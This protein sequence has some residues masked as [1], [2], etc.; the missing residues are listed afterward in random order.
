MAT[1]EKAM[2]SHP[3]RKSELQ[4]VRSECAILDGSLDDLVK[5]CRLAEEVFCYAKP[6]AEELLRRVL[7]LH[8]TKSV[9][10]KTEY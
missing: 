2:D 8:L 10:G 7:V 3:R 5:Q 4:I 9:L 1:V 6:E